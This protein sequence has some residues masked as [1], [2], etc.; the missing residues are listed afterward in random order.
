MLRR[1][2]IR[3]KLALTSAALTFAI[4]CA[5][6][7]VVGELTER[8]IRQDFT[9]R[10]DESADAL[11]NRMRIE[12]D[13]GTG[14]SRVTPNVSAYAEPEQAVIRV[15]RPDGSPIRETRRAP[16]FGLPPVGT[17]PAQ[18]HIVATRKVDLVREDGA[19]AGQVFVQYARRV[20]DLNATVGQVKFF[21]F[22]GVLAGTG[23]AL[24]A[25]YLIAR[26]A[27]APIAALTT[28]AREIGATDDLSRR[29]PQPESDDEVGELA[30]TLDTML[31]SLQHSRQETE[32]ML[33]RQRQFVADA[34][35]ELRT[36][37]TS[38]LANLELLADV[39][40]GEKGEAARSA[41][42]SSQ[43]MRRLVSDLLLLARADANRVAP[44]APTDVAPDITGRAPALAAAPPSRAAVSAAA[45][46]T[47]V[48]SSSWLWNRYTSGLPGG[49]SRTPRS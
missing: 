16:N 4:L 25:G 31:T 33:E 5:F 1:L 26:R 27:M 24:L 44:R 2:S 7:V 9:D 11:A 23:F 18:E 46:Q 35:H 48:I 29:V 15:L 8:Q 40:D 38:V 42:R 43:R 41:L 36:P 13:L 34:S 28:T 39:L 12:V 21:L 14:K 37:L 22:L 32:A 20:S 6:A 3:W 19:Y 45:V 47:R 49:C 30:R 17:V 10:L